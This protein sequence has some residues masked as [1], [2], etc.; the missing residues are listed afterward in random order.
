MQEETTLEVWKDIPGYEGIYQASSH[1]NIRTHADKTTVTA[2]HGVRHWKQRTL[3]PK[4][5]GVMGY[6]VELWKDGKPCGWLVA[7]LI[8]MTFNGV[9][10]YG[11]TVNHKN[12][13]R[14]D[15]RT[16][17]LEWVSLSDNIKH[18][19]ETGLYSHQQKVTLIEKATSSIIAF[20]SMSQASLY[21][22]KNKGFISSKIASKNFDIGDYEIIVYSGIAK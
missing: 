20:R 14:W 8:C 11:D 5:N 18:G 12:G 4:S 19:Y 2:R 15:N 10:L 16:E 9:P 13:D 22:N 21:L 6:R 3:R 17:N 7:R 1:G